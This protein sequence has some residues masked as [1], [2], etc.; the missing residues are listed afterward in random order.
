MKCL[1]MEMLIHSDEL[2]NKFQKV[3]EENPA[4]YNQLMHYFGIG[5]MWGIRLTDADKVT[6]KG[7]RFE[8]VEF[9]QPEEAPKPAEVEQIEIPVEELTSTT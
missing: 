5:L 7:F 6:V 2:E 9:A 3:L 4:L 8:F 1:K